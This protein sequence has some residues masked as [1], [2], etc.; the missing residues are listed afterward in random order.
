MVRTDALARQKARTNE[1][2]SMQSQGA[3]GG[4]AIVN[5]GMTPKVKSQAHVGSSTHSNILVGTLSH[6]F[7]DSTAAEI[8]KP[9]RLGASIFGR[10]TN[11]PK[12]IYRDSAGKNWGAGN[13]GAL[14]RAACGKGYGNWKASGYCR[15]AS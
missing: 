8:F 7:H 4:P 2:G 11:F 5:F 1:W 3:S 15:S 9:H 14:M 10:N 6:G 13:I 12:G